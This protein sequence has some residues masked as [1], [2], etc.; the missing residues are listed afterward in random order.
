M[1]FSAHAWT[2]YAIDPCLPDSEIT[3]D[4]IAPHYV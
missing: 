4:G 1:A 3:C 2:R